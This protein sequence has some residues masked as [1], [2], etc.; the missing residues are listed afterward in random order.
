MHIIIKRIFLVLFITICTIITT[1]W[2]KLYPIEFRLPLLVGFFKINA[3]F[4][5]LTLIIC[6]R[7][8]NHH[9]EHRGQNHGQSI[10][11]KEFFQSIQIVYH[12]QRI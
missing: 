7:V 6:D 5:Y 9:P 1:G 12:S 3:C 8:F 11:P 10:Q 4:Q 2:T